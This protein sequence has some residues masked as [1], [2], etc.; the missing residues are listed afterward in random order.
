MC[1]S[2]RTC[3]VCDTIF[4]WIAK[5]LWR[6]CLGSNSGGFFELFVS[7][8]KDI[9]LEIQTLYNKN[10]KKVRFLI[11]KGDD[12]MP[13]IKPISDLRNYTDVLKEVDISSRVYLTRN[14]RGE[15]GILTMEEID[16]LDRL[17][18]IYTL[19]KKLQEAEDEAEREGW[20]SEEDL[21]KELGV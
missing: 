1:G 12:F 15:Y 16:E 9:D 7:G 6:N 11:R 5:I 18:A 19:N 13:N 14:G 2:N 17:K 20:I 3:G 10:I 8:I 21:K 4:D